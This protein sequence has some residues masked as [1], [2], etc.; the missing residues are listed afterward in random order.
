MFYEKV[1]RQ[2]IKL[3]MT[4]SYSFFFK[5]QTEDKAVIKN[6]KEIYSGQKTIKRQCTNWKGF[7]LREIAG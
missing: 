2:Q 5:E 4:V 6:Q 1:W 3:V 7:L